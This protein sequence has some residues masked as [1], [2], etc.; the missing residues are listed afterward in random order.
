MQSARQIIKSVLPDSLW[1]YL[2]DNFSDEFALKSYSQEGED[3]ILRRMFETQ[4]AGF[5]VDV[6]AHHPKRFSNTCFFYKQ[7]WR[8][9]NIDAMPG[10]MA[11][12]NRLRP[13][14]I[15]LEIAVS[16]CSQELTYYLFDEPALNGFSADIS[17][18]RSLTTSLQG[19]QLLTT[20]TLETILDHHLPANQPIDFLTVDVEGLDLQVLQS[21]NWQKYRPR[22]VVVEI[23]CSDLEDYSNQPI[24]QFLM[25]ENYTVYAKC[26]NSW[27]FKSNSFEIP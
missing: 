14:D 13:R 4:P 10:S 2:K 21:N 1:S 5:Y 27:I 6:G 18:L 17:N 24:A 22:S 20:Q 26:V 25:A 16:N 7:G 8:G 3:M 12:F 19:Q 23:L 15:N 11:A 9:I